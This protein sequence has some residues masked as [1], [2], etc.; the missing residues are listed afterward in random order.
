VLK[1]FL[2][3]ICDTSWDRHVEI[4][5]E[6]NHDPG[7]YIHASANWDEARVREVATA[8]DEG[9]AKIHEARLSSCKQ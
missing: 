2:N 5:Q 7:S 6:H 3:D 1:N 9:V 4:I 8:F